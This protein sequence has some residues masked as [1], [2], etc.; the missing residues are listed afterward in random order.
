MMHDFM[1]EEE[2]DRMVRS[3]MINAEEQAPRGLWRSISARVAAGHGLATP[4][5][6]VGAAVAVAAVAVFAIYFGAFRSTTSP[7]IDEQP[8]VQ[9][10]AQQACEAPKIDIQEVRQPSSLS[11]LTAN[12]ATSSQQTAIESVDAI[13]E[14]SAEPQQE[15]PQIES[16]Q[17]MESEPDSE[18]SQS[19]SEQAPQVQVFDPFAQMQR[20]EA[21]RS[22]ATRRSAIVLRGLVGANDNISK[23]VI[24]RGMAAS[25]TTAHATQTISQNGE[26]TF[27]IPI[28]VG[29]GFRKY[30]SDRWSIGLGVQYSLLRRSFAG[31]YTRVDESDIIL[32]QVSGDFTNT[33][34]Y[35]G[36]PLTVYYDIL[37]RRD[38]SFYGFASGTVERALTNDY[39]IPGAANTTYHD[40][41]HGVQISASLGFGIS[42]NLT[43][44]LSIYLDPSLN[45]YF[46]GDQPLSIRTEQPL[47]F[48]YSAG[49]RFNL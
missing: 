35:I 38:I 20:D 21:S 3:T 27:A 2:F 19:V 7:I 45:Y 14:Q 29:V 4:L 49:F 39:H 40:T 12:M 17:Q 46:D 31:I 5:K 28:S 30:V 15:Q 34:Q 33:Q 11:L 47:Q 43:Q 22:S 26:S 32:E 41:V 25:G 9:V 13:E 23:K 42:F 16:A 18:V 10:L 37:S 1:T 8:V 48:S 24:Y 6:W 44:F 36:V